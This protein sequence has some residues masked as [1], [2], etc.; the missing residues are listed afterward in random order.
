M[1]TKVL[2]QWLRIVRLFEFG[3]SAVRS[4]LIGKLGNRQ[5]LGPQDLGCWQPAVTDRLMWTTLPHD[6]PF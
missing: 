6:I 2:D 5:I 3:R 4:C 1:Q